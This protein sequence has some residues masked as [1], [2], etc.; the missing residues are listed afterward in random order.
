MSMVSLSRR[1]WP[2]HFGHGTFMNDPT[3]LERR[4]PLPVIFTSSG[5]ITGRSVLRHRNHPAFGQWM[6]GMGVPQ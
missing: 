4:R 2:P 3:D 6:I 1:A 5:S